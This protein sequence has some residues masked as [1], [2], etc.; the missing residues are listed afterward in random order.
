VTP[1]QGALLNKA[2]TSIEAAELLAAH[3][4]YEYAT[5]RAYYAMLYVASALLLD[6]EM[7]FSKHSAVIA[8]FG[9]RFV[10]SGRVEP[11]YHRYLIEG[12]ASRTLSDYDPNATLTREQAE[13]HINRGRLF[14]EL[15]ERMLSAGDQAEAV[16]PDEEA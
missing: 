1:E 15:G 11:D 7:T 16:A 4:M 6:E 13:I 10:K 14:L 5:S 9:Q 2:R 8:A 12:A 3:G